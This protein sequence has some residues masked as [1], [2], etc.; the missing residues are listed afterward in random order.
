M[1]L[2]MIGHACFKVESAGYSIVLD[3]YK[4]GYVPG[5]GPVRE[6]AD[7]VLCSH[8]HGDH[9]ARE[10]VTLKDSGCEAMKVETIATFHDPEKGAKRGPNTIHIMTDGKVKAAHLGDLGCELEEEQKERL[11]G[12]DVIMIPVGGFFTIDAQQAK[13]LIEEI[14]PKYVIPMHYRSEFGGF[15]V[16]AP[17]TDFTSLMGEAADA[18]GPV[19]D[20]DLTYDHQVV[21]LTPQNKA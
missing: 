12:M 17:L 15:D 11:K 6:C 3:P 18:E 7:V 20:T 10:V 19:F 21:V 13:K 5:L 9:G 16:I 14:C 2:T 1:K 4:D 8:E